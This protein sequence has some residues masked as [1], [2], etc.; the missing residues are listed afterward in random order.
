MALKKTIIRADNR[1]KYE[2][3]NGYFRI[4]EMNIDLRENKA[5]IHVVGYADETARRFNSEVMP[6]AKNEE[7]YIY[8]Q[9]FNCDLE[10]PSIAEAYEFLK[11]QQYFLDAS[12]VFED[13]QV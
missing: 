8:D 11:T 5:R 1:I 2:F 3:L 12:D 7:R 10:N 13:G 9:W 6:L 4:V